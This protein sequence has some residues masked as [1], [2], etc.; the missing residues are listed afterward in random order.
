MRDRSTS[1]AGPLEGE[2][3]SLGI[4]IS[5]SLSVKS[6]NAATVSGSSM[7]GLARRAGRKDTSSSRL[8]S[9]KGG[10][11]YYYLTDDPLI[12]RGRPRGRADRCG[13][14]RKGGCRRREDK[15][16]K[17]Q[18]PLVIDDFSAVFGKGKSFEGTG[19]RRRKAKR[20]RQGLMSSSVLFI[21]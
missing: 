19:R 20:M 5:I 14:D 8:N 15:V 7:E 18:A 6:W 21:G 3:T 16:H 9:S 1:A 4:R 10:K 11:R 13:S 2:S 17:D 12:R